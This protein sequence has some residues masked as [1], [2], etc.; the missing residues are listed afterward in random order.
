MMPMSIQ[1]KLKI[2]KKL[3]YAEYYDMTATFDKLYSQ[4]Q[5]SKIFT[6]L[7]EIITSEENIKLAYRSIKSNSGSITAGTDGKTIKDI[8]NISEQVYIE[9]IQKR[10][11]YYK[12]QAVKRVEIPKPDGRTRPLGIPTIWDR[13]VQQCILQV[14][15]PICEAKFHERNN[16]FRPNRSAQNA[17]AQCYRMIQRQGL[18]FVVDIDISGFFDNVNHT[19]LK[20]QIW[21]LGIQDK[22]LL[23]IISEMLKAPIKMKNGDLTY[24]TKGTPQG[25]ILSPILSNV[26]LNELDWWIASQWEF[27]P[28]EHNYQ[29]CKNNNGGLSRG[30]IFNALKK[31]KLKEMYI[32]RYADDF[33]IFC[34]N[35]KDALKVFQAVKQWLKER[36]KLEIN[37]QK[38]KVINLKRH[39]SEFLGFK[40]KAVKKSDKYVVKSHMKDKAI[41]K[42]TESLRKIIKN[43]RK[44]ENKEEEYRI[45]QRYNSTIFGIH[46]Y[47]QIAT[48]ISLDCSKIGYRVKQLMKSGFGKRIKKTGELST[49]YLKD[50]YG[51]SK[52]I[53]FIHKFALAPIAYIKTKYPVYKKREINKYTPQGR[54]EVHK[55]LGINMTVL[56]ALM[57]QKEIGRSV[58][59]ADNRISLYSAQHGKCAIT[60]LE[61]AIGEIYCHHKVPV[62]IGGADNYKNLVIVHIKAHRLIHATDP[63]KI[64]AY[65][66]E[67]NLNSAMLKKANKFREMA[68]LMPIS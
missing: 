52:Q 9:N 5:Q 63:L 38:S 48:H 58:E 41:Q 26:V 28:T 31:T 1:K 35:R 59:F 20:R 18:H 45:I 23:C 17:I 43:L 67:L 54:I 53:R 22:K 11:Q 34:R 8:K 60:G 61:L 10:L 7:M 2:K 33:K 37:E 16:G 65:L 39:Y 51:D 56:L 46:N 3:R 13:L 68:L 14:L 21:N 27:M 40:L 55:N 49:G 62:H 66:E 24:P 42:E 6:N 25:G 64:S 44:P 36:L 32:V 29:L 30:P 19:K 4:S 57:R 12:P 47:Y 50:K 15:D